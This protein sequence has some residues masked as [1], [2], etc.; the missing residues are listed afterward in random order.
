MNNFS[1]PPSIVKAFGLPRDACCLALGSIV[2]GEKGWPLDC[3]EMRECSED[4]G[5]K[6]V[7]TKGKHK[8]RRGVDREETPKGKG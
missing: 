4:E 2:C 5:P 3:L 7:Q 6:N 8:G 1:T